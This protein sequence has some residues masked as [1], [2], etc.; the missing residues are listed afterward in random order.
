[1]KSRNK[2]LT[3]FTD[4]NKIYYPIEFYNEAFRW[5]IFPLLKPLLKDAGVQNDFVLCQEFDEADTVILPMSWNYYYHNKGL[6]EIKNYLKAVDVSNKTLLS[7]I[8]GDLGNKTPKDFNG[9]VLRASGDKSKLSNRHRGIP[10]FVEDPLKKHYSRDSIFKRTYSELPVIGFC[11]LANPLRFQTFID[12]FKVGLK[13]MLSKL[14]LNYTNPQKLMSTTYFRYKILDRLKNS[15]HLKSNFIIRD[16]YRAGVT[17]DKASH[18]TTF[19]FYDNMK[20]SDYVVCMR[21]AGNFSNRFYETLAMGRIP[22]FVNTDCLLPLE[23][24]IDWKKHVVWVEYEDRHDI[25]KKIIAFHQKLDET[26]LNNL[27]ESNRNLWENHLQL[28]PY[29]KTLLNEI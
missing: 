23:D 4:L 8:V 12:I 3:S 2:H 29:F 5:H 9:L 20:N 17:T 28:L 24:K 15:N 14:G 26:S 7:I 10:I 25:E 18:K 1:M 11:G 19:E 16:R 13:N 6:R 21:G 27:F 22:V